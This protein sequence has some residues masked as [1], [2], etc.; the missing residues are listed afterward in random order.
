MFI[1]LSVECIQTWKLPQSHVFNKFTEQFCFNQEILSKLCSYLLCVAYTVILSMETFT[2]F[3][4]KGS[5]IPVCLSMS[6]CM[7][8]FF[9]QTWLDQE[10]FYLHLTWLFLRVLMF[11]QTLFLFSFQTDQ[12]FRLS[13]QY[14]EF[15]GIHGYPFLFPLGWFVWGQALRKYSLV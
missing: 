2:Y 5:R 6:V 7:S 11:S 10:I 8:C 13:S 3:Q 4:Y 12:I 15:M 9:S 14:I 1:S